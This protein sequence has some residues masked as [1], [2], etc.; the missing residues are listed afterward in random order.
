VASQ[1]QKPTSLS[2]LLAKGEGS[3]Q[4]LREGASSANRALEASRRH[5]PADLAGRV[6]G[7]AFD[8]GALSL[9]VESAAW[10]TRL[11]YAT[12]ELGNAIGTELGEPIR[13]VV[14]KVRPRP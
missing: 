3:L 6:W 9:L 13:K 8:G 7:A 10:A 14:V 1:K 5:L 11:R 12:R 2:D 4:R